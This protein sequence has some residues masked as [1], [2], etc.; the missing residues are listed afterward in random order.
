MKL[1]EYESIDFKLKRFP[2]VLRTE[3]KT[4]VF[5]LTKEDKE[6][7]KILEK[8]FDEEENCAGLAAPQI[9]ISKQIIVFSAPD[10]PQLK[11]WR[12]D[13]TQTM[14]KSIWIN[15]TYEPLDEA[16]HED[17]EA[18]FSVVDRAG[19][20]KRFKKIRY[21][22]YNVEGQ[23]IKG[24]AEGFLARIIQ[25]EIDHLRGKLFIDYVPKDQLLDLEHYREERRRLM[26]EGEMMEEG[27]D[28]EL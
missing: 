11:K 7:I 12:E 20:V 10:D 21:Q 4:L 22:A 14:E 5:P 25:H 1:P 28:K 6:D 17:Y 15:P 8:K 24:E 9:G 27:E 26:E 13:L 19:N 2:D 23:V 3:A 16:K 18:C